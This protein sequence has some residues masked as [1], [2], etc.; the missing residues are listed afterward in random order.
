MNRF[1]FALMFAT[2][3]AGCVATLVSKPEAPPFWSVTCVNDAGRP[4]FNKI[5]SAEDFNK[6][7]FSNVP[8][9]F[10]EIP[11]LPALPSPA[12]TVVQSPSVA[13]TPEEEQ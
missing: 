3:T 1:I 11:A 2:A 9:V 12:P 4:F 10:E 7:H 8:C 13:P 6:L 5:L